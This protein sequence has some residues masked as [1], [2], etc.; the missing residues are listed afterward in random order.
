MRTHMDNPE[1]TPL[2]RFRSY[3]RR[4]NLR[5]TPERRSVLE[6]IL[7]REG[8]FDAEELLQ[9]LRRKNRRVSRATLYRTLDHLREAGLVRMHRF[10]R[11]Q[12]HFERNYGR[13][14]HDH[15][16]CDRC[17]Q[18]IE[19]VND[20]IERLQ[21]QVCRDHG[22]VANNHVMQI[23]GVCANCQKR[24][25]GQGAEMARRHSASS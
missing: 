13:Q 14:H 10:G 6:V 22:F 25:E 4:R 9:F 20:Q 24:D 5:M 12:A 8:H 7:S 19:F 1:E 15:M 17:G 2:I 3:L 21:D 16:V 11:G 23:F 18:V